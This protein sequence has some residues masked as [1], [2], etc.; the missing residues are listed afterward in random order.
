MPK[1]APVSN[2]VSS[3]TYLNSLPLSPCLTVAEVCGSAHA[4][5]PV[6]QPHSREE[7][8]RE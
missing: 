7:R 8:Q 3:A 5:L 6:S 2:A 4:G 1:H